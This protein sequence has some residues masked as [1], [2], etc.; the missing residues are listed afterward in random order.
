MRT[1]LALLLLAA[2]WTRPAV[3]AEPIPRPSVPALA[4]LVADQGPFDARPSPW[5][6]P[7]PGSTAPTRSGNAAV[8]SAFGDGSVRLLEVASQSGRIAAL[9]VGGGPLPSVSARDL[10]RLLGADVV[11]HGTAVAADEEDGLGVLEQASGMKGS[12]TGQAC[13]VAVTVR[14]H[15]GDT[16]Q[17]I[18]EAAAS[19][20][21]TAFRT[22][23]CSRTAATKAVQAVAPDLR[24]RILAY[25]RARPGA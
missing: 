13:T 14:A 20:R 10:A 9:G 12:S 23:D 24:E 25:W 7:A 1:A 4:V 6:A 16:G 21:S 5:W 8:A 11:V 15:R 17:V 19:A 18:A 3:A 22:A 2:A